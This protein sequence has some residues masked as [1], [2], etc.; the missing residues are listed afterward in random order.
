[1]GGCTSTGT[2]GAGAG[3]TGTGGGG[4]GVGSGAGASMAGAGAGS[5]TDGSTTGAGSSTRGPGTGVF[6]CNCSGNCVVVFSGTLD[7]GVFENT[8]WLSAGREMAG[9]RTVIARLGGGG[10]GLIGCTY[11]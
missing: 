5:I 7:C 9:G 2:T 3:G 6:D 10:A 8:D 1:M 11:W 4:T